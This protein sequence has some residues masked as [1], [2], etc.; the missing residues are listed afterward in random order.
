MEGETWRW[1]DYNMESVIAAGNFHSAEGL[2]LERLQMDMGDASLRV[3]GN[4]LGPNQDALFALTDFPISFLQPL[5]SGRAEGD[6]LAMAS[7]TRDWTSSL[8]PRTL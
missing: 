5:L 2:K 8:S 4:I 3:A 7:T 6:S 1:G